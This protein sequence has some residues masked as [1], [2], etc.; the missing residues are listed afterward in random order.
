MRGYSRS[1]EIAS[2]ITGVLSVAQTLK[3][4]SLICLSIIRLST[5]ASTTPG[6]CLSPQP[7]PPH[8]GITTWTKPKSQYPI[9]TYA[10]CPVSVPAWQCLPVCTHMSSQQGHKLKFDLSYDFQWLYVSNLLHA[11]LCAPSPHFPMLARTR[12]CGS[13]VTFVRPPAR[14]RCDLNFFLSNTARH[15]AACP[16]WRTLKVGES[17]CGWK[18]DLM[19]MMMNSDRPDCYLPPSFAALPLGETFPKPVVSHRGGLLSNSTAGRSYFGAQC[20]SVA[21]RLWLG[22]KQEA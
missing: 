15:T 8:H 4:F 9:S 12:E 2:I 10:S 11:L 5:S 22:D 17:R 6:R 18:L 1:S 21:W 7:P 14:L 3:H 20:K 13:Q 19:R 16:Y